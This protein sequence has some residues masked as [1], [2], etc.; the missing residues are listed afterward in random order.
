LP[1]I[2][3]LPLISNSSSGAITVRFAI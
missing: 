3:S 1:C 2:T